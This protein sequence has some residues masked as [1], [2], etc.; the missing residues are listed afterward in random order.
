MLFFHDRAGLR[1]LLPRGE[2]GLPHLTDWLGRCGCL[3]TLSLIVFFAATAPITT[4]ASAFPAPS[5]AGELKTYT[6]LPG[7]RL[8]ELARRQGFAYPAIVR[9][10]NLKNPNLIRAGKQL[11]L[12]TRC[13]PPIA[14]EEGIVVNVPEYR[15]YVFRNG[16]VQAVYPATVGLPTWPTPLGAFTVICKVHNPAWY[17]PPDL[18]RRETVRR[19]VVPPGPENPLGDFWIGTSLEHTGIH[20]T[21]APMSMGRALSHGCVRL[22]PEH[23]EEL[24]RNVRVGD[25][26]E[27]LYIPIKAA[28]DGDDILIEVHPDVYGIIPDLA[29]AAKEMLSN[30]GVWEQVDPELL[31]RALAETRGIPVSV[32][33]K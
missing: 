11:T 22:Y 13:I 28:L 16:G 32:K 31:R 29:H 19:E 8:H 12:P 4:A 24:V 30:L 33:T 10:N 18:A 20:G 14:R 3:F 1:L 25:A 15:L 7:D 5:V 23:L 9:A 17:M 26:G 21:N 2:K 27:I 6:I